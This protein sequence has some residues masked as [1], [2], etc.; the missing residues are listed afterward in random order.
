MV[1]MESEKC[2][3]EYN[4]VLLFSTWGEP[5]EWEKLEYYVTC[6]KDLAKR[7][8]QKFSV[9]ECFSTAEALLKCLNKKAGLMIF[10]Q[11]TLLLNII[12]NTDK[13]EQEKIIND[14]WSKDTIKRKDLYISKILHYLRG[15]K[16]FEE[17]SSKMCGEESGGGKRYPQE[18]DW[19]IPLPGV[20]S[21]KE[22][23][24]LF[25]WRGDR[26]YE[27]VL[28]GMLIHALRKLLKTQ[29]ESIA[30]LV[31]T[32]H[33]VNYF[34]IALREAI[35]LACSL[36]V[37][38]KAFSDAERI[39]LHLYHYNAQPVIKP[40]YSFTAT[41]PVSTAIEIVSFDRMGFQTSPP[42][43]IGQHFEYLRERVESILM[44]WSFDEALSS[45]KSRVPWLEKDGQS[46]WEKIV[47]S[48]LL[49]VRG[50]LPWALR[51]AVDLNLNL[52]NLLEV[53]ANKL[54]NVDLKLG[55][56]RERKYTEPIEYM[57]TY[58]WESEHAPDAETTAL[59][60]LAAILKE[61]SEKV[62][63]PCEVE[64]SRVID[65]LNK[66]LED[67]QSVEF[68]KKA[69]QLLDE[70]KEEGNCKSMPLSRVEELAGRIYSKPF[71]VIIQTEVKQIE[72]YFR[73]K[74]L[75]EYGE[76]R[77]ALLP[78]NDVIIRCE[79]FEVYL[80]AKEDSPNERHFYAH[81]GL[82]RGTSYAV[83]CRDSE[84]TLLLGPYDTILKALKKWISG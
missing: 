78:D 31:D 80:P 18:E 7:E 44:N 54:S 42:R 15:S 13:K 51:I 83:V 14:I 4:E 29:G 41:T 10:C 75:K 30:V 17:I 62:L 71:S 28:G 11:D 56:K 8:K 73:V 36:W 38:K 12:K 63:K 35:P 3:S 66:A 52:D 58:R 48:T 69:S 76:R 57:A 2:F 81:M 9:G 19:C 43:S 27:Y 22:Y 37:L 32:S 23:F 74:P 20:A 82:V 40:L 34:A 1:C 68:L 24:R 47:A 77:V 26:Y 5:H 6:F 72:N 60:T 50:V 16:A 67:P 33:G 65:E 79:G 84:Y 70:L 59:A 25:V 46:T 49:F 61:G 39:D 55:R 21:Y 45:L 64:I 53:S